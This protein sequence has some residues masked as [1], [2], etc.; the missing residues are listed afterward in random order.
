MKTINHLPHHIVSKIA[1]GEVV[2]R[3]ASAI[4]EL[5]ENSLDAG[6]TYIQIILE[7]GGLKKIVVKDDG[8]GM[9]KEDLE[10]CFLP[11]TTSKITT[12]K[13][14][15]T[16]QSFGFRGEA[17]SSIAAVSHMTIKSRKTDAEHGYMVE[18][19]PFQ[20][21]TLSSAGIP[22]GTEIEIKDLFSTIPARKKFVKDSRTELRHIV[23]A[24]TTIAL[25]FPRVGFILE[26]DGNVIV[27]VPKEQNLQER[28]HALLGD[29]IGMQMMPI[30]HESQYGRLNG[31]IGKPQ[32]AGSSRAHQ[33]LFVNNRSITHLPI[34]RTVTESFGSLIE[35]RTHAVFV[36][37]LELPYESVDVNVH[38]RKEEVAFAYPK[39]ILELCEEAV[40]T[41]LKN[42][43]ITYK[44]IS[45]DFM[46]ERGMDGSTADMLK[47][48]V[49]PWNL[50]PENMQEIS[51]LHNLYL[52]AP[53]ADGILLVDQHAAHERI[54]FEQF[55][56]AFRNSHATGAVFELPESLLIN[57]PASDSIILDEHAE[58]LQKLGFD[59]SLFGVNTFKLCA[60]PDVFKDRNYKELISEFIN[61]MREGRNS[62]SKL[63]RTTERTLA[64]MACRTA[65]KAGDPLAPDE[66]KRLLEKLLACPAGY[67]CPHGRPTHIEVSMNELDK[68][69]KRK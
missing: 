22:V 26:H 24:I 3:P 57:L 54:L 23:D 8:K 13:D 65:V 45:S 16:I 11:H 9:S 42:N 36:V 33:Y 10:I 67:T 2:D 41:T 66:R 1:A 48:M 47:D 20:E 56:E 69:F 43:N 64:F 49:T 62:G 5:V 19:I 46:K 7:Q 40:V 38:P 68:M 6:A 32:L 17:L 29:D 28:I 35:P 52:V 15:D 60:V 14:L 37:S 59:I 39:N 27:N 31:F 51:Q 53:T 63:D 12:E 50:K 44:K 34:S 55:K 18:L 21:P 58:T 25:S 4:K 30:T 61:D